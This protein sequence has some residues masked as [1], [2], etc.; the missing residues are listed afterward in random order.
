MKLLQNPTNSV[1]ALA[2]TTSLIVAWARPVAAVSLSL[3]NYR[4]DVLANSHGVKSAK[5]N[6]SAAMM[7]ESAVEQALS[8][9]LSSTL[10]AVRSKQGSTAGNVPFDAVDSNSLDI[11]VSRAFLFGTKVTLGAEITQ[12]KIY[13][14]LPSSLAQPLDLKSA[15][16]S[17]YFEVQQP[18]WSNRFGR[19][20][21]MQEDA[22]KLQSQA[23][24][25]DENAKTKQ[26]T[27]MADTTYYRMSFAQDAYSISDKNLKTAEKILEFVQQKYAKNLYEKSD[28]LQAQALVTS[29]RLQLQNTKSEMIA[30][31]ITF[32]NLRGRGDSNVSENLEPL[33]KF[34]PNGV[35]AIVSPTK[36]DE[37]AAIDQQLRASEISIEL[38]GDKIDPELSAFAQYNL[39]GEK[40]KYADAARHVADPYRS[41][42]VVGVTLSMA[43]NRSL[44]SKSVDALR[45][46]KQALA[47]QRAEALTQ[48]EK[49]VASLLENHRQGLMSFKIAKDL[50]TIQRDRVQN[51]Q[52]EFRN[53]RSTTYNMLLA[54]QDL[55]ESELGRLQA[56][57]SIKITEAQLALYKGGEP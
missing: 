43:L 51:Q 38:E 23:Q 9:R 49:E 19:S 25:F 53:G 52:K 24:Q 15:T 44:A 34:D 48:F 35:V 30:A 16:A 27:L 32:N 50:E 1:I 55:N 3:E 2:L 4:K 29:R 14:A 8:T 46:K 39:K 54:E 10:T 28:L 37:L 17:P 13:G 42:A 45:L 56:A 31:S 20:Y 18:L 57:Y 5:A 11:N 6:T 26:T 21:R 36:R 47:E 40:E 12:S 41:R 7:S 22:L 33:A